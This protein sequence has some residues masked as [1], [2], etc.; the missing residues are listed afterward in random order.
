MPDDPEV[1]VDRVS[2][3]GVVEGLISW[4]ERIISRLQLPE[5]ARDC[6]KFDMGITMPE[7]QL[8]YMGYIEW[9]SRVVS[10]TGYPFFEGLRGIIILQ[11]A[12]KRLWKRLCGEFETVYRPETAFTCQGRPDIPISCPDRFLI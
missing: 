10:T 12:A 1:G 2:R 9:Q 3:V 8:L 11:S 4:F 6:R 5:C 7:L